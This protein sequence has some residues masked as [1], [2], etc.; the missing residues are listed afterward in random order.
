MDGKQ[1]ITPAD[2]AAI[3]EPGVDAEWFAVRK[4]QRLGERC[5]VPA[6][7]SATPPATVAAAAAARVLGQP[8]SPPL[9]T[10]PSYF[11]TVM[12]QNGNDPKQ[13][14]TLPECLPYCYLT[15]PGGVAPN[16]P[17]PFGYPPAVNASYARCEAHLATLGLSPSELASTRRRLFDGLPQNQAKV[18]TALTDGADPELHGSFNWTFSLDQNL[19]VPEHSFPLDKDLGVWS[20]RYDSA[21]KK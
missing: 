5:V 10:F 16:P 7:P 15:G 6:L 19:A 4:E 20:W 3:G 1:T 11:W 14:G 8:R 2:N 17:A 9:P 18:M 21:A 12:S 13:V